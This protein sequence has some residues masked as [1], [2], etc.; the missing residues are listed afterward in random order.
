MKF[1]KIKT[2]EDIEKEIQTRIEFKMNEFLTAVQNTAMHNWN[3][4]FQN[5]D[6]R[7]EQKWKTFSELKVLFEKE[8]KMA[9]PSDKMWEEKQNKLANKYI[10]KFIDGLKLRG[11]PGWHD[12][13]RFIV[14]TIDKLVREKQ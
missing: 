8:M 10:D 1:P 5:M 2:M 9:P 6:P 3:V 13:E 14:A 7:A 4:A 11:T 12:K